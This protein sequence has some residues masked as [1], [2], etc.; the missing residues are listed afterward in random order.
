MPTTLAIA[1]ASFVTFLTSQ[2]S[3][4][5]RI[6]SHCSFTSSSSQT[7]KNDFSKNGK[8]SRVIPLN[9]KIERDDCPNNSHHNAQLRPQTITFVTGNKKK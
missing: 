2:T 3:T 9:E 5:I 4:P 7:T 1:R 6:I 8:I